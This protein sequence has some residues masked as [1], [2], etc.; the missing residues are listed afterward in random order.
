MRRLSVFITTLSLFATAAQACG[1][2]GCTAELTLSARQCGLAALPFLSPENDTRMNLAQVLA[3][4]GL[5]RGRPWALPSDGYTPLFA[6]DYNMQ[7]LMSEEDAAAASGADSAPTQPAVLAALGLPDSAWQPVTESWGNY[8]ST[9]CQS[10]A[11]AAVTGFLEALQQA[12]LPAAETRA[13]AEARLQL[14]GQCE[15]NVKPL[16]VALP[17]K[18]AGAEF[19]RYLQAAAAF[20]NAQYD[21]ADAGF[22]ALTGAASPWIAETA[23][24]L[25]IRAPLNRAQQNAVGEWGDLDLAKV[26]QAALR[27]AETRIDDYLRLYPQGRYSASARRLYRRVDWLQ[28]DTESLARRFTEAFRSGDGNYFLLIELDHKLLDRM[29]AKAPAALPELLLVD[30]LRNLR[31]PSPWASPDEQAAKPTAAALKKRIADAGWP[32]APDWQPY[33]LA[34]QRYEIDHDYAAAAKATALPDD[35]PRTLLNFS[36]RVLHGLSLA[37]L[38]RWDEAEA[39][40]RRQLAKESDPARITLLQL[41]LAMTLERADRLATVLAAD[42]PISQPLFRQ[43]VLPV[44]SAPLLRQ[45]VVAAHLTPEERAAAHWQLLA[46]D[47]TRGHYTDFASDLTLATPAAIAPDTTVTSPNYGC[48]PI[49]QLAA[50]LAEAPQDAAATNC[51]ADFFRDK[52]DY[53]FPGQPDGALGSG[54]DRFGGVQRTSLDLY[55]QVINAP[56]VSDNHR[57]YALSRALSCFATSG[58]NHCGSADIPRR[59][60]QRWFT[61]LKTRYAKTEWAKRQRI[62]W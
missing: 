2:D 60:R 18:G 16:P 6:A 22:A 32:T 25:L 10:N 54:P 4:K 39:H 61:L 44:A 30:G 9:P 12:A 45:A 62:W 24:Y 26:D 50:R 8:P 35:A 57:A 34:M 23:H 36:T 7:Q 51:L 46:K 15:G 56:A 20:Y 17:Q 40:W 1:P 19:T 28:Q 3:E 43:T 53:A 27:R 38:Q 13:L 42:T 14:T 59:E 58:N 37:A 11:G 5:Y 31:A 21:Q 41:T 33:L 49:A 55:R 29:P 48:T 52:T 47:L